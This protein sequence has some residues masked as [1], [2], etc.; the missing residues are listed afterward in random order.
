MWALH[1]KSEIFPVWAVV[2]VTRGK[3]IAIVKMSCHIQVRN[4][5]KRATWV[6]VKKFAR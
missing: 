1:M 6:G 3:H 5:E 4:E 2:M